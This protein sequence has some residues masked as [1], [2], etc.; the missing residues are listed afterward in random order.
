MQPPA[1]SARSWPWHHVAPDF[2]SRMH[3]GREWPRISLITPSF[4]QGRFIEKTIRSVLLQG[5]PNLEYR[6]I[7]GGSTD[8][9]L[10][11]LRKY[12]PWLTAWS[13]EKDR[14]Q[15][16]AI[17]KG[18]ALA[19]GVIVNWL[20][21]DDMLLQGA[22]R[23]VAAAWVGAPEA[24]A[25]AGACRRVD[26]EGRLVTV[27]HPR[28][29]TPEGLADWYFTGYVSQPACFFSVNM[30]RR[31]GPLREDLFASMDYDYWLRLAKEGRFVAVD[32][33]WCEELNHP[34]CKTVAQAGRSVAEKVAVQ[35]EH[36][37]R[38]IAIRRLADMLDEYHLLKSKNPLYRLAGCCNFLLRPIVEGMK[39]R[40]KRGES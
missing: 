15:A 39:K 3:D 33:L 9:T 11:V 23:Q 19:T 2:P 35:I 16:H 28:N 14:G 7:D 1:G 13:S 12:E 27:Y 40:N 34:D 8:G 38:D 24:V 29:L 18:L 21:S 10:D 25:W 6:V 5:Y 36:G 31:A 22:L 37:H 32:E 4:N 17:N 26:A 20:N 30:A